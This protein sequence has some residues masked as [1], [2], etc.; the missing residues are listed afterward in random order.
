MKEI[1]Y[2]MMD[3]NQ[4]RVT[5][6][7]GLRQRSQ[8]ERFWWHGAGVTLWTVP[9]AWAGT[10]R[11]Q[12]FAGKCSGVSEEGNTRGEGWEQ[13]WIAPELEPYFEGYRQ[14]LPEPELAAFLWKEQPFREILVLLMDESAESGKE[15]W[16]E[17]FLRECYG[18][19][20]GLY[21]TGQS[22]REREASFFD[23]MYEQS[24][25]LT[26]FTNKIPVTDGRKT[27]V[28]DLRRKRRPPVRELA[29]GSL[30]L[31][32]TSDTQ[33]QRLLRE[34]RTDISYISARNYLDT[35]FKARYNAF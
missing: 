18:N 31:D 24:G 11:L 32:F 25:L 8:M 19:L 5:G 34:K 23:W 13:L 3:Q 15:W 12:L 26:C 29:P 14:P 6:L 21:L 7:A 35:A 22:E 33:K 17:T 9:A 10:R 16:Q 30:Y 4:T 1:N 27:A 2:L 20:N 28:A